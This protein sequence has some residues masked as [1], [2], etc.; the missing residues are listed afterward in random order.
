MIDTSVTELLVA[1]DG[2]PRSVEAAHIAAAY[3]ERL[4]VPV[5]LVRGC[6]P[7]V[8][9]GDAR[10]W[11]EHLASELEPTVKRVEVLLTTDIA[12]D[13]LAAAKEIPGSTLCLSSHGRTEV[14]VTILGSISRAIVDRSPAP[15]LLIGPHAMAP[16]GFSAVLVGIDGSPLSRRALVAAGHWADQLGAVPWL[17]LVDPPG[18]APMTGDLVESADLQRAAAQLE[19]FG[20]EPQWDVLHDDHPARALATWGASHGA[21]LYVVG[22]HSRTGVHELVVGSVA[23]Q[24]VHH[25]D[26]AVLVAG[27]A[28]R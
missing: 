26:R 5:S 23:N 21:A 20:L 14:G 7:Y 17:A 4:A 15:V 19:T 8:S 13:V 1:V 12:G 9:Y 25:A 10:D 22:A 3:A 16:T 24:L 2:T 18:T 27:P 28:C 11:A 6:R